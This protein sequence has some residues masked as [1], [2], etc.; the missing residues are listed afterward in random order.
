LNVG[1]VGDTP[2]PMNPTQP[3]RQVEVREAGVYF[4]RAGKERITCIRESR[5]ARE[6]HP[7]SK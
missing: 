3:S 6:K 5:P 7:T 1:E 2:A 4:V